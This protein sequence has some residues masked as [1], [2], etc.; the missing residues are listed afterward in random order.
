MRILFDQGTPEPPIPFLK[1][2][3]VTTA[4]ELGWGTLINGALLRAAE[5]AGFDVLLTTDENMVAQQ[6]LKSRKSAIVVLGN[7]Q[8]RIVQRYVRRIN[9]VVYASVPGSY[10]EVDIPD[11]GVTSDHST[12][13]DHASAESVYRAGSPIKIP[14]RS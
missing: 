6:N 11:V 13:R 9:A 4:K 2:H 3:I 1:D 5:D 12:H 10:A 14:R 8:W 7:S